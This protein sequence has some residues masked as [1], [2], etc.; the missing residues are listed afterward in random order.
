M[1]HQSRDDVNGRARFEQFGCHAM[2]EAVNPNMDS[3]LGLDAELGDRT[4]YAVLDHVVR[5]IWPALRVQEEIAAWI[6]LKVLLDP[7]A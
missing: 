6:W 7:I 5:R 2:S 1:P 3:L 4:V